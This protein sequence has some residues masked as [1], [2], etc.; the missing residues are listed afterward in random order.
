MLLQN[1][2]K[3]QKLSLNGRKPI[4]SKEAELEI[5]NIQSEPQQQ[6]DDNLRSHRQLANCEFPLHGRTDLEIFNI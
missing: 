1:L 5:L 2:I 6:R 4:K 3:S